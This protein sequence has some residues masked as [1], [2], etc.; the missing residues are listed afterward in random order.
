MKI[1]RL[2]TIYFSPCGSTKAVTEAAASQLALGRDCEA[3]TIDFTLPS[4]RKGKPET[5]Q[6]GAPNFPIWEFTDTDLVVFGMPTYAGRIPNKM[7]PFVEK[8]FRGNNTPLAAMVTFGNRNYDSSLTELTSV[9]E[10]NGFHTV[11]AMA[12]ACRHVFTEEL[13]E[14][15][16]DE[17]DFSKIRSFASEISDR[18]EQAE[19]ISDFGPIVI[20]GR[21]TVKPYY[22]PLQEDG[23]PAKFLKAKPVTDPSRCVR[24]GVCAR[25]CP[26]GAIDRDNVFETP[27]TCIKCQACVRR[28]TMHAKRFED[29]AFLSHV[30]MLEKNFTE[31]KAS[32][33]FFAP[34]K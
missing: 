1:N 33:A 28:C 3:E 20:P 17:E 32:E 7:L 22:T 2:F 4:A 31:R 9:L 29:P 30:R 6:G 11:G 24:C 27:G 13:A 23:T 25:V 16:P 21:E 34:L 10:K 26:M 15:R 14:D 5:V 12:E 8:A 19:S 18:I